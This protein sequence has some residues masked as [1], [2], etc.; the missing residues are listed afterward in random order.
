MIEFVRCHPEHLVL[1]A[2]QAAQAADAAVLMSPL[3]AAAISSTVAI[4]GFV[5]PRCVGCAGVVDTGPDNAL[6]WAL[7]SKDVGPFMLAVSRK[8]RRVLDAYP[9]RRVEATVVHGFAAGERW[10][11][12]LGFKRECET[13]DRTYFPVGVT[14]ALY[15]R[16]KE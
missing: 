9:A 10:M 5:G 14:A 1:F 8:V 15:A 3:A 4:S 2:P 11:R 6:V 7:L 13:V 16:V 12:L